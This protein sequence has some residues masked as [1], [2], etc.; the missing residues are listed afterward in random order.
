[1]TRECRRR[2]P[3]GGLQRP[4]IH[5]RRSRPRIAGPA[6]PGSCRGQPARQC[7]PGRRRPLAPLR[8][9]DRSLLQPPDYN[10]P[11][12][13]TVQAP[14]G[15]TAFRVASSQSWSPWC[16][17]A[18]QS[19][20]A[21]SRQVSRASSNSTAIHATASMSTDAGPGVRLCLRDECRP[22]GLVCAD[23]RCALVGDGLQ[24]AVSAAQSVGSGPGEGLQ[25]RFKA[26]SSASQTERSIS[27]QQPSDSTDRSEVLGRGR[28]P[29]RCST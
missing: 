11:A 17:A 12:S 1:V 28:H 22:R 20:S 10:A 24:R 3:L 4:S 27:S 13:S 8:W 9:C 29:D 15:A 21:N 26:A 16:S 14:A 2:P 23:V 25:R 6:R 18:P 5:A 19:A 7:S